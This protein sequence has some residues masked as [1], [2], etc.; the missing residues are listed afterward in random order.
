MKT[1]AKQIIQEART[2]SLLSLG[3]NVSRTPNLTRDTFVVI[4][5]HQETTDEQLALGN[6]QVDNC[7]DGIFTTIGQVS[8]FTNV[9]GII[10]L[11][12]QKGF[13]FICPN[14]SK[15]RW[16]NSGPGTTTVT[17]IYEVVL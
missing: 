4:T 9:P 11:I 1:S 2:Y 17:S 3:V 10:S 5:F 15:Y 13:T 8:Q 6:I 14:G 16:T 7:G 12:E